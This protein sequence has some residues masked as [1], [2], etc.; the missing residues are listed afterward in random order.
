M[1]PVGKAYRPFFPGDPFGAGAL[2]WPFGAG[3]DLGGCLPCSFT[4]RRGPDALD[5][6]GFRFAIVIP[7]SSDCPVR[8]AGNNALV[9][10]GAP[11]SRISAGF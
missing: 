8:L 3:G 11:S 9:P 4:T 5:P 2:V 7:S 6:E 10:A 1:S